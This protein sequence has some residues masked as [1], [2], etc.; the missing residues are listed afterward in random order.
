MTL[1]YTLV[2]EGTEKELEQERQKDDTTYC[3]PCVTSRYGTYVYPEIQYKVVEPVKYEFIDS[4]NNIIAEG[5]RLANRYRL[6]ELLR[7]KPDAEV[8]VTIEEVG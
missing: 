2:I 8:R 3:T 6:A 4:A 5:L 7:S 1:K